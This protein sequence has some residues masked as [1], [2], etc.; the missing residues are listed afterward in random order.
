M[1]LLRIKRI[2]SIATWIV[3]ICRGV[4]AGCCCVVENCPGI[5]DAGNVQLIACRFTPAFDLRDDPAFLYARVLHRYDQILVPVDLSAAGVVG[6]HP[7]G[8]FISL[9]EFAQN[10][11]ECQEVRSVLLIPLARSQVQFT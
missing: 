8:A 5:S 11:L 6:Y 2:T 7:E 10:L 3:L 1:T 9:F 4:L